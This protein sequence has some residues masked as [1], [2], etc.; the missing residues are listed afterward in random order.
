MFGCPVQQADNGQSMLQKAAQV[1]VMKALGRR[2]APEAVRRF[3]VMEE[4]PKQFLERHGRK[5][6][7][8]GED[9]PEH[10]LRV[11][12]A[13]RLVIRRIDFLGGA[14]LDRHNGNLQRVAVILRPAFN[15]DDVA[16]LEGAVQ[17][18]GV[19]PDL[20]VGF[21]GFVFQ[22]NVQIRRAFLGKS[23]VL[24]R[25]QKRRGDF[26]AGLDVLQVDVL[27]FQMNCLS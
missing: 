19:V 14:G 8:V 23:H 25:S 5:R 1:N 10:G 15:E 11:H 18:D 22:T 3:F 9:I 26:I 16:L 12:F 13:H 21:A 20:A 27:G 17:F 2:R 4:R 6:V 24:V 7:D